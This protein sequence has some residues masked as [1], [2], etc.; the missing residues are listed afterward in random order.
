MP[1]L[2]RKV[3]SI[4]A[5]V[6]GLAAIVGISSNHHAT[7][8]RTAALRT[9]TSSSTQNKGGHKSSSTIS[10]SNKEYAQVCYDPTTGKRLENDAC[11]DVD[12]QGDSGSGG[13]S[14]SGSSGGYSGGRW[15]WIQS[16]D[17]GK[18]PKTG[19]KVSGGTTT[20]PSDGTIFRNLPS[21]G[22]SFAESFRESKSSYTVENS[23]VKSSRSGSSNGGFGGGSKTGGGTKGG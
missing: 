7:T 9:G 4:F 12:E 14:G 2:S 15:Y 5:V 18:L 1:K 13:S 11:K 20:R 10:G 16:S 17:S 22:G 21:R 19:E 3:K 8:Q 6:A 23:K